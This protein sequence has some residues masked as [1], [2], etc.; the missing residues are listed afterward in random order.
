MISVWQ[1]AFLHLE[2]AVRGVG[3]PSFWPRIRFPPRAVAASKPQSFD[4]PGPHP[5]PP[6]IAEAAV[7]AGCLPTMAEDAQRLPAAFVPEHGSIT[8]MRF[9]M[10]DDAGPADDAGPFA[11][12]TERVVPQEADPD[13]EPARRVVQH[14]GLRYPTP[15]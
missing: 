12:D 10:V 7:L 3:P 2:T 6:D 1:R 8:T 14:D 5:S 4:P 13:L 15:R 9:D 11:F